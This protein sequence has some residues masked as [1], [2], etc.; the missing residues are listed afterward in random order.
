MPGDNLELIGDLVHNVALELGSR[1]TLREGGKTG[2]VEL[3]FL[4]SYAYHS[5]NFSVG[6][7]I[8]TEIL[9]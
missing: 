6:T 8:V 4:C 2:K 5:C 9:G 1:F 3:L 7:G